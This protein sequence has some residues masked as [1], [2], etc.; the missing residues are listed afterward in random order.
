MNGSCP[1]VFHSD[2]F[3]AAPPHR[4][5]VPCSAL[6]E[7]LF[8]EGNSASR[9]QLI[10]KPR[11]ERRALFPFHPSQITPIYFGDTGQEWIPESR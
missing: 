8:S 7:T 5:S 1:V 4:P 6:I 9:E 2:Y 3:H 10:D 11:E